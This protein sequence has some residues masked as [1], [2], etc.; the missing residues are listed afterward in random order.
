MRYDEDAHDCSRQVAQF[1]LVI[2]LRV[3]KTFSSH[4]H[5]PLFLPRST[6]NSLSSHSLISRSMSARSNK[7]VH[8]VAQKLNLKFHRVV[9]CC[10]LWLKSS[11][12]DSPKFM[13][14]RRAFF[15]PHPSIRV[16]KGLVASDVLTCFMFFS[17][18]FFRFRGYRFYGKS[19]HKELASCGH[20]C[21]ITP[22]AW[23][24]GGG[25]Q[26][27]YQIKV[28][29]GDRQIVEFPHTHENETAG[30]KLWK[31]PGTC[32]SWYYIPSHW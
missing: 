14:R 7:T 15:H 20:F 18:L 24:C 30:V 25:G 1:A 9:C 28:I 8:Y 2:R 31:F 12:L 3:K 26:F 23:C 22:G 17:L 27:S 19:T 13:S 32:Q 5:S 10:S 29:L 16:A 4:F 6:H 11:F 21:V